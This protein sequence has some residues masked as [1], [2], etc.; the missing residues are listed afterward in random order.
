MS[1]TILVMQIKH[2]RGE[3]GLF[4]TTLVEKTRRGSPADNRP[5]TDYIHHFVL[6]YAKPGQNLKC[7][8][9]GISGQNLEWN[10]AVIT[11]TRFRMG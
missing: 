11:L 5:S 3:S 1:V 9:A 2:L 7:H 6:H 4:W 8:R 10:G